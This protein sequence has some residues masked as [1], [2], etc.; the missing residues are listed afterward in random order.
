[1]LTNNLDGLRGR[2]TLS[3][4]AGFGLSMAAGIAAAILFKALSLPVLM[5][6]LQSSIF[7]LYVIATVGW[8]AIHFSRY[9]GPF[10]SW[11]HRHPEGGTAPN[12]LHRH[13]DRFGRDYWGLFLFSSLATPL[14]CLLSGGVS[15]ADIEVTN[16][17]YFTL[18][19]LT[20][21]VLIGL[22]AYL[23]AQDRLGQIVAHMGLHKVQLS[24]KSKIMLLGGFVPLLSYSLLLNY[25]W[26]QTGT[27]DSSLLYIWA[28]L[29]ITTLIITGL[30]IQ[31]MAQALRPV[32]MMLSRHGAS[33]RNELAQLRAQSTDEIG[34]M[35]QTLGKLFRRLGDQESHIRTV[36]D[37]AA[38]GIIV[39]DSKG[40]ID[41]F[42]PAAEQLFGYLSHEIGGRTLSWLLPDIF[43]KD[44]Q[45][46][47]GITQA[48][49][50]AGHHRNG[51]ALSVSVRVSEM[52]ISGKH[53]Y[54]CLVADIS[55]RKSAENQLMDAEA[56]YR[57]L[58]ETAHD[59]VWSAD[60]DG[61]WTYL[62]RASYAI[63]GLEPGQMLGRPMSD[64]YSLDHA[65]ENNKVF[66]R[67]TQG[68]E[69][70]QYE[71]VHTD[72]N[73][74]PHHLSFNA[75]AH[76]DNEGNI[77]HISGTARDISE[78]KAFQKQ[79]EFQAEHDALTGLFN[80]RY[81]QQELERTV[82]RVARSGNPCA[83]CYID[84]DQFKYINDTLGHAAGD[85]LL[86]EISKLLISYVREGDLL[87]R[88]GGDEFTLLLYNINADDLMLAAENFRSRFE[89]YKFFY[90]SKSFNITCSIG[91]AV[92]DGQTNSADEVLSHADL[93]CNMAKTQG[94][95]CTNL[96]NPSLRDKDGM[97]EDMGWAARV[98]EM[99]E[100]DRFQLVYQPIFSTD[101]GQVQDYEVLVRMVCEDGG[102][103][104]PGGFMPAAERFG[105]IH[106]VDRWIVKHAILKLSELHNSGRQVA[107]SI[108]LS[109]KAFEDETLLPMIRDL[110][111]ETR[112]DPKWITFE[113]TETAAIANINAATTFI[114]ALKDIGCQFA[115]DDFGSGFSSFAYLKHLP[116]DRLKIDGAF[117][118]AMANAPV[119]QA[120]VQS[121]NQVAHALGKKTVAEHVEDEATLNL[122]KEYGID[123]VQGNHIG[124][125][126][127]S[128]EV[129]SLAGYKEKSPLATV[130]ALPSSR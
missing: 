8:A 23:A 36:I 29:A 12:N 25:H 68:H 44:N 85:Q 65:D 107:F 20:A 88:F 69:L 60:V 81:F 76:Y 106:A 86:I 10:I 32:Q 33:T 115:L 1:M 127:N 113:V 56:R 77:I 96:Y 110:I 21:A 79:L 70:V 114:H 93:A 112:L 80:R 74:K 130:V 37:G 19:Q 3:I 124:I 55:K 117:V 91:M 30:S 82:S 41:N 14:A 63:Y 94:R 89:K 47:R 11:L 42:N 75:K 13:L 84:L 118:H 83:L 7:P 51:D 121:M 53:M 125:P 4:I 9:L 57:D 129:I 6:S 99:L 97:A 16:I 46:P 27:L 73:G 64:F 28:T 100:H 24:I 22:P 108:N 26:T 48:I 122:L 119:D 66:E 45:K 18:L 102:V 78:Q 50:T 71:T 92:I 15:L 58:V 2:F 40:V 103:I 120:M 104:L 34:Y 49:E 17:I 90:D 109:G 87:S 39:I 98:R 67:I 116:V 5:A 111:T 95:N 101:D 62:N 72:A 35:T 105:L 31:G 59:L 52:M 123:F 126:Q 43:G 128:P 61:N 54:T 38:E